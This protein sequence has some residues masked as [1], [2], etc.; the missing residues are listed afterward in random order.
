MLKENWIDIYILKFCLCSLLFIIY[1]IEDKIGI[2][3]K[4]VE[5]D[6]YFSLS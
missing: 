1:V 6:I 2:N 4:F 5:F 3:Y